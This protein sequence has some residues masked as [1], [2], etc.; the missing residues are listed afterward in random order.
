MERNR[1]MSRL[2][3][4]DCERVRTGVLAQPV[5]A[6]SSLIYIP[7]GMLVLI[8]ARR[9]TGRRR[10]ALTGMAGAL[11]WVGVGSFAYHGPQ[12]AWAR[13]AHDC[14]IFI[15]AACTLLLIQAQRPSGPKRIWRS[16]A[17]RLAAALG[18]AAPA[19]YAGGRTRSL[20]CRPDSLLQLHGAWH[21]LT[22]AAA[23]AFAWAATGES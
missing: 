12:P 18:A 14:S 9:A 15:A 11:A 4:S 19:A 20:L 5:N 1:G 23:V 13:G 16:R 2:G 10:A 6:V 7:A 21:V 22:A 17:G 3:G 8:S